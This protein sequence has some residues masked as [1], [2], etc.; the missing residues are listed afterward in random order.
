MAT[1]PIEPL[2]R[3]ESGQTAIRRPRQV[4]EFCFDEE[5]HVLPLSQENLRYYY[6]PFFDAPWSSSGARPRVSL[7]GG[8]D[9]W[10]K[11]DESIDWHLDGLLQ[12]IQ[13]HEE[14][15]LV[16]GKHL[17]DARVSADVVAWRGILTKVRAGA[18]APECRLADD[19]KDH[20][21]ALRFLLGL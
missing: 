6:P 12:T 16:Q 8:F 7:S 14:A 13:A 1:F 15:Q 11:A 2:S 18:G 9:N 20:G 5:H 19:G 17:D 4:L 3:F 10:V 21:S